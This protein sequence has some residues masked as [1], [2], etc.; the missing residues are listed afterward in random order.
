M[1]SHPFASS[2]QAHSLSFTFNYRFC[3]TDGTEWDKSFS[4][5]SYHVT[6][7]LFLQY[8]CIAEENLLFILSCGVFPALA[9]PISSCILCIFS[10]SDK[11]YLL[12]KLK[13]WS[14]EVLDCSNGDEDTPAVE[15]W[16]RK[17]QN[18][19]PHSSSRA[20][21]S[22]PL[23]PMLDLSRDYPGDLKLSLILLLSSFPSTFLQWELSIE[24]SFLYLRLYFKDF[25]SCWRGFLPAHD[26]HGDAWW[27]CIHSFAIL[28]EQETHFCPGLPCNQNTAFPQS[29]SLDDG[30]GEW[31]SEEQRRKITDKMQ[32]MFLPVFTVSVG[33]TQ[34][35]WICDPSQAEY[36]CDDLLEH[37]PNF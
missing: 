26:F 37:S 35:E 6:Q 24:Q 1:Q 17:R 27:G 10:L 23:I 36:S 13:H 19:N 22:G 34:P 7:G 16:K 25:I 31:T 8:L 30:C 3:C 12:L 33:T 28:I 32:V 9:T 11:S 18:A 15:R 29:S 21:S 14:P 20:S 5:L 2:L 4:S